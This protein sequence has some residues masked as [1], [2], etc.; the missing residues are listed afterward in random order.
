[1]LK[2]LIGGIAVGMANIIPGVSG[3]TMMVI[4]GLFNRVMQSISGIFTVKNPDRKKDIIFLLTLGVGA[5]IGLVLFA[6]ILEILFEHFPTQTLFS[7][8]GMV[9][10]SI[11]SLI[12]KEMKHDKFSIIPFAIGCI[13]IFGI[14]MLAPEETDTVLSVFPDLSIG[15]LILMVALGV[16]A[17][18]AM[19]IPG[20][21]GSMLLLILGKYY[22]FKSLLA[23]VTSFELNVILPL[24][25]MGVGILLGINLSSKVTGHFLKAKHQSTMNLILGLVV[26]SSIVLI[27]FSATYTVTTVLSS[28]FALLIGGAIVWGL[29]KIA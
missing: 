20:V 19:F 17:G 3:G 5:V 29:E 11:P 2:A 10:F 6:K 23:N 14:G 26:A 18:G 7:F 27:P 28:A 8:V 12:K 25:F 13:I 24:G 1:M 4:L 9:V 15:Y 21:S 22:L 16:I